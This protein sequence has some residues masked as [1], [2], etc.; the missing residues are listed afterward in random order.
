MNMFEKILNVFGKNLG[1]TIILIVAVVFFAYFSDGLIP[2]ILTALS[3]L[4]AYVCIVM[5]YKEFKKAFAS[6]PVAQPTAT[7]AKKAPKKVTKKKTN[8]K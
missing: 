6:K 7:V 5:L 1:Y 4:V 3:A 2:G 8:K